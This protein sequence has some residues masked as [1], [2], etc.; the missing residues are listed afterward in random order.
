MEKLVIN[1]FNNMFAGK[2]VLV[3]GNTG[4]K[5]SWLSTWLHLLEAKIYG[6]SIGIPTEPS[7][8]EIIKDRIGIETK[9]G[10]VINYDLLKNYVHQIEPDFIFHLAAQSIVSESYREPLETIKTNCLGTA[11]ILDILSNYNKECVAVIITSD[12][13]YKNNE[14]V[15]GYR[16][17]DAVGGNDIYSGSK[18]ATEIII[19]SYCQSFLHSKK[20]IKLGVGRA[21]NV[22]G[23]GDWAENRI[24]VDCFKAWSQNKSVNL[25]DKIPHDLGNTF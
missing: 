14:W 12:K 24:V 5:G 2:K 16:E 11:N 13:S 21:G 10:D 22:I 17:T 19:N 7:L 18:G 15:W 3:T 23:G 1:M 9:F 20:N 4:F 8:Y 6:Y 25:R